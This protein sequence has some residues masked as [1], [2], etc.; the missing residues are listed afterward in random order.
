MHNWP[1][2]LSSS[3]SSWC[4]PKELLSLAVRCKFLC[5]LAAVLQSDSHVFLLCPPLPCFLLPARPPARRSLRARCRRVKEFGISP[6]DI[7][8]SQGSQG[9][10]ADLSPTSTFEYDDFAAT[11]PSRSS[12]CH[13]TATHTQTT[14]TYTHTNKNSC[15]S[16]TQVTPC[17]AFTSSFQ[18]LS[19]TSSV[20]RGWSFFF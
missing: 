14:Y 18:L 10:R 5:W 3:S 12:A 13:S 15:M 2:L 4:C 9:S 8:F 16:L 20:G 17:C 11:S 7:P 1:A 19:S 6:S